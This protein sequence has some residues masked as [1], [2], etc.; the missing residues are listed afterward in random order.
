MF[1]SVD[2][3][4][5][6]WLSLMR[7]GLFEQLEAS[8]GQNTG[9]CLVGWTSVAEA[10]WTGAVTLALLGPHPANF[11]PTSSRGHMTQHLSIHLFP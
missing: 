3:E 9:V 8:V 7:V 6:G 5:N 1:K 2:F 4:Q 11:G 10:R